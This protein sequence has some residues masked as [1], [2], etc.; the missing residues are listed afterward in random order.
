MAKIE[1][2]AK[3]EKEKQA[4]KWSV[5]LKR[6]PALI[7][8]DKEYVLLK[9]NDEHLTQLEEAPV[10]RLELQDG[11]LLVTISRF[12]R[13][14]ILNPTYH[15]W[16]EITQ[17]EAAGKAWVTVKLRHA[18][19]DWQHNGKKGTTNKLELVGC[20]VIKLEPSAGMDDLHEEDDEQLVDA[21]IPF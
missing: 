2:V 21:D 6:I 14:D 15:S 17:S 10:D 13:W 18:H 7:W 4:S 19:Y 5:V 1:K 16:E 8:A 20:S 12:C 9:P 11:T 3:K